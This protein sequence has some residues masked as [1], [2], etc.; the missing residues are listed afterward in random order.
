MKTVLP[1][2][3][4][5]RIQREGRELG[6]EDDASQRPD[7]PTAGDFSARTR[8]N[9]L[10]VRPYGEALAQSLG[11]RHYLSQ[12]RFPSTNDDVRIVVAE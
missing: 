10:S 5:Q 7:S 1:T 8:R 6:G 11:L 9:R 4:V 2:L 3:S 12:S